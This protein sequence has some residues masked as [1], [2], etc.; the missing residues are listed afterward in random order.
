MALRE[1]KGW[2][3]NA[4]GVDDTVAWKCTPLSSSKRPQVSHHDGPRAS[5]STLT[6]DGPLLMV[7]WKECR[8]R[9][10]KNS[11]Q[12]EAKKMIQH[13]PFALTWLSSSSKS[14]PSSPL[15]VT[16][17]LWSCFDSW[18]CHL[19]LSCD[20]RTDRELS[21]GHFVFEWMTTIVRWLWTFRGSHRSVW[22]TNPGG[23][24]GNGVTTPLGWVRELLMLNDTENLSYLIK[25]CCCFSRAKSRGNLVNY[26]AKLVKSQVIKM[27]A[28]SLPLIVST[29][30]HR[31]ASRVRRKLGFGEYINT[32]T[33][34]LSI[35]KT[36]LSWPFAHPPYW[37]RVSIGGRAG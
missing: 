2:T 23:I 22:N 1:V 16:E 17:G 6:T 25:D 27:A 8:E 14:P 33:A 28:P 37:A 32:L 36:N 34:C 4:K 12:S 7:E 19:G 18:W 21:S 29:G 31:P 9:L 20:D 26:S 11:H 13:F 15:E 5:G 3:N 10:E 35:Q 24:G 30:R